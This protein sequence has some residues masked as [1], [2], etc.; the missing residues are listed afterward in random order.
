MEGKKAVL[1]RQYREYSSDVCPQTCPFR[2]ARTGEPDQCELSSEVGPWGGVILSRITA[3][4]KTKQ[5]Q[6]LHGA[7][8]FFGELS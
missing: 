6:A 3:D 4:T 2:L 5:C 1:L 8:K 7:I